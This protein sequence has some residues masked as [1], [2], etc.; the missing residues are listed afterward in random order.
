M[1][2]NMTSNI[3]KDAGPTQQNASSQ[4]QP[5]ASQQANVAALEKT[6]VMAE[7]PSG[8]EVELAEVFILVPATTTA[9]QP[10]THSVTTEY[11][12]VADKLPKTAS[13]L[14]LLGLLGVGLVMAGL[15]FRMLLR[16]AAS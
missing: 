1:A 9:A 10:T 16:R 3:T 14:P 4:Q 12:A 7:Q 5:N 15:L 13:L 8:D 6:S 11:G 2:N